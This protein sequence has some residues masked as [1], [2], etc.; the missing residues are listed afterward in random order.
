LYLKAKQR[1][2]T[3]IRSEIE[4]AVRELDEAIQLDSEYAPAY[5]Q[6]AI[7]TMLLSDQ[8]YGSIPDDESNRRGKRFV[9]TALRLDPNL[10]EGWAALGLYYGRDGTETDA[11]IDALVNALE[12]NPNSIDA[13]NWLHIALADAGDMRGALEIIEEIAERD[14]LYRPAFTNAMMTFNNFGLQ[15]KATELLDRMEAFDPDNPD[16]L[17]ARAVNYMYSGRNGAGLQQMEMRRDMGGMSG[18]AQIFLSFGLSGTGQFER[19]AVEGSSYFW[20][21][22]LYELGRKEEAFTQAYD[23]ASSG[24]PESLFYL[25]VRE[26]RDQDLANFLEERWPSVTALADEHPGDSVGYELMANTAVAYQRLGNTARAEEAILLLD[27]WLS[28]LQEQG[29]DN[30]VFSGNLAEYYA[31]LGD[32]DAAIE[33]LRTAVEGGWSYI[34][35]TVEVSPAMAILADDPRLAELEEAML[36]K[37]NR[38]RAVVGLPPF[39]ADYEVEL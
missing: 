6:R 39:N 37:V 24:D 15:D 27:R 34:G 3:R 33:H 13:S 4:L 8:Q 2:Y 36:A 23:Q 19:A 9:D 17:L 21:G 28:N 29:I 12:I 26:G 1:N 16:L 5:A 14:P 35:D 31:I 10:A 30:F 11:G 22:A 18:V 25:L 32:K 20:P 38:E 7:A